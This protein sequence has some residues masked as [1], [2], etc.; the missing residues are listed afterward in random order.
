[1]KNI[2]LF[3]GFGRDEIIRVDY[4]GSFYEKAAEKCGLSKTDY[5]DSKVIFIIYEIFKDCRINIS[6]HYI[7]ITRNKSSISI[8]SFEDEWYLVSISND[9]NSVEWFKCDQS[10]Q[11]KT[12]LLNIKE[13]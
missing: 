10:D 5:F 3:E 13:R 2:K 12:L 11:L 9:S 7:S 6:R 4:H 8:T 1:M